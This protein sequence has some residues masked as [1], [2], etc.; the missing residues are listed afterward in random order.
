LPGEELKALVSKIPGLVKGPQAAVDRKVLSGYFARFADSV[1]VESGASV[2]KTIG[3]MRARNLAEGAKEFA[4][5]GV[6]GRYPGLGTAIGGVLRSAVGPNDAPLT[7]ALRA[8]AVA[9]LRAIAWA[10]WEGGQP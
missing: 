2:I 3:E 8:K 10:C 5:L 4:S 6:K 1:A 9:A 7:P